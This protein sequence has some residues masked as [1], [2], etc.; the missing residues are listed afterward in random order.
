MYKSRMVIP[1]SDLQIWALGF[2]EPVSGASFFVRHA[3]EQSDS[4]Q[5]FNITV[6]RNRIWSPSRGVALNLF[7]RQGVGLADKK[8]RE[9]IA[10]DFCASQARVRQAAHRL[11]IAVFLLGRVLELAGRP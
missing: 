1:A 6:D 7:D 10:P 5:G 11:V 8:R 4:C 9:E 2:I 3:V